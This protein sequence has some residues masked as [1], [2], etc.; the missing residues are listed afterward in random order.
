MGH[1]TLG[2]REDTRRVEGVRGAGEGAGGERPGG[3]GGCAAPGNS[4]PAAARPHVPLHS[5]AEARLGAARPRSW[6]PW[7]ETHTNRTHLPRPAISYT[8]MD[9]GESRGHDRLTLQLHQEL[10]SVCSFSELNG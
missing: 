3:G 6:I 10:N 1:D 7:Y 5:A 2:L 8:I 9:V 4:R